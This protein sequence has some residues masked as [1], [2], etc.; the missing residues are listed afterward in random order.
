M[1]FGLLRQEYWRGLPFPSPGDLPNPGIE[2]SSLASS[3]LAGRFFSTTWEAQSSIQNRKSTLTSHWSQKKKIHSNKDRLLLLNQYIFLDK[4][5]VPHG[6]QREDSL[7]TQR[8]ISSAWLSHQ[9]KCE[10]KAVAVAPFTIAKT[11]KQPKC[12]SRDEST[13]KKWYIHMVEYYPVIKK[14]KRMLF[15]AT[16]MEL[17][18][19]I[20][21]KLSQ[22]V[23]DR[24]HMIPLTC[25]M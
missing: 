10:W 18:I 23:K 11:W 19:N 8:G 6:E 5:G 20:L 14:N 17:G 22:R 9:E 2:S 15:A 12:P 24:Y 3:A 16:W 7:V 21:S 25:G 13:K 4:T 1:S